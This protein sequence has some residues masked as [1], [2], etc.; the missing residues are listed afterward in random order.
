MK[1]LAGETLLANVEI[2]RAGGIGKIGA[3]MIEVVEIIGTTGTEVLDVKKAG[4]NTVDHCRKTQIQVSV[5]FQ[6]DRLE[7]YL[8]YPCLQLKQI[9]GIA[10]DDPIAESLV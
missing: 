1:V 8:N 7:L 6:P 4:I 2:E 10:T 3:E 9:E 5:L